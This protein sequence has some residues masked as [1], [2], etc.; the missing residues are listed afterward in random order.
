MT[1]R[2]G[3]EGDPAEAL[4]VSET[5]GCCGNPPL[6]TLELPGPEV[7]AGPCCGTPAQAAAAGSCCGAEAKVEA[8]AS[9]AG[10]C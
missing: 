7:S 4:A 9:G 10:C 6:A 1:G 3:F 5:G 2:D 8:V